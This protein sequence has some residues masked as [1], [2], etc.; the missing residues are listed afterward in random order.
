MWHVTGSDIL[1]FSQ[2]LCL[3]GEAFDDYSDLVCGTVVQIRPKLDKLAIWTG[4]Y[5]DKV[6]N[7]KIG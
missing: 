3:V 7:V 5:S 1:Y 6:A 4:N 2:L